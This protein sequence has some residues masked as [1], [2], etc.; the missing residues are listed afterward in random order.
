[1]STINIAIIE[2]TLEDRNNLE[3]LVQS[4][5]DTHDYSCNIV[6]FSSA[7]AFLDSFHER[8][9]QIAF[10][11]IYLN[12]TSGLDVARTIYEKDKRCHLIFTT[13]SPA[14]ARFGYEIQATHYLLKPLEAEPLSQALDFCFADLSYVARCLVMNIPNGETLRLPFGSI[15]YIECANRK[16]TFHVDGHLFTTTASFTEIMKHLQE[17]SRFVVCNK[18]IVV[19]MDYVKKVLEDDLLM[20]DG[21]RVPL[22][23]RGRSALKQEVLNHFAQKMQERLGVGSSRSTHK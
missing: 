17:D 12:G 1:M 11:D 3:N 13:V 14:H 15:L 2:D 18:G 19:N 22:R 21:G 16:A 5:L 7:E 20:K 23:V 10:I 8:E 6:S 4:Y 9:F